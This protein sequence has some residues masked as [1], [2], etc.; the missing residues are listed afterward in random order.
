MLLYALIGLCL[1]LVGVT[2]L[3][4]TYVFYV[5]HLNRQ[6]KA[7]LRTLENRCAGLLTRLE[8][9]EERLAEQEALRANIV[10]T[11]PDDSW[12]EVIDDG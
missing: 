3:M 11:T 8:A 2:G 9:A 1:A 5:D 4:F 7:H 6:R 12:A 10:S